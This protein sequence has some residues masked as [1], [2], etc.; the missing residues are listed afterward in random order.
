[1][2]SISWNELRH[3]ALL[4]S[5]DWQSAKREQSDKQTFWNE[6][7]HIFG[8]PRRT[9]ATFEEPVARLTGST[10]FIDLFRPGKLLVEIAAST[11]I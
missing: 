10:G 7:F 6:F 3:R 2:P 11:S 8:V 1:M 9:L 4:F 5:R